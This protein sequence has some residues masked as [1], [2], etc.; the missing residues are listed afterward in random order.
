MLPGPKTRDEARESI[1]NRRQ[2]PD[3]H[4]QSNLKA[5]WGLDPSFTFLNHGSY[6]AVPLEILKEQYELH[7]HIESQPVRFYGREIEEML[8]TARYRLAS[9]ICADPEGLVFVPNATTGVNTVLKSL[10]FLPGDEI[11]I[12]GHIYN[13]CRNAVN[14]LVRRDRIKVRLVKVPFPIASGS[15][16]TERVLGQVTGR[17]RL[18][19]LD[20]ITS[21]TALVFPVQ[22][23]AAEL[24][25]RNIDILV[26]GAHAPGMIPLNIEELQVAYYTGNCH[27]WLCAPRGSA[28]LYIRK[29]RRN[30][31]RPLVTSHGANSTRTDKS[32]LHLEFDWTGTADYT[33]YILVPNCIDFLSSLFPG[34]WVELARRNHKLVLQARNMLCEKFDIAE[35]APPG[36]IGSMACI[37]V[38][39]KDISPDN[40]EIARYGSVQN[41]LFHKYKIEVPVVSFEECPKLLVRI[42][43]QAYNSM[44]DY[45]KLACA[46]EGIREKIL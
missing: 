3:M 26:D 46:L 25:R 44:D 6:G 29:D 4:T 2:H 14:T 9:F 33:P 41:M 36:M 38:L 13:A 8:E 28:F 40:P 15:V 43:A 45:V 22:E 42:S 30:L 17:T 21:P 12:T 35:P 19:L 24:S 5:L 1:V 10:S 39:P 11:V 20:H 27:K 34:G 31:I 16:V 23:L 7:L 18:V 37:P 32:F